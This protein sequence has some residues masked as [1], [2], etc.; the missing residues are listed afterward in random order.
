MIK[1]LLILMLFFLSDSVSKLNYDLE[2]IGCGIVY[3][4]LGVF[5]CVY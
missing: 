2:V 1:L 3:I 5:Y 4:G